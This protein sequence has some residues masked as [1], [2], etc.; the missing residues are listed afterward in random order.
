MVG[1][2]AGLSIASA[3]K[4]SAKKARFCAAFNNIAAQFNAQYFPAEFEAWKAA[5]V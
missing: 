5:Q 2:A 4:R 1:L 3:M